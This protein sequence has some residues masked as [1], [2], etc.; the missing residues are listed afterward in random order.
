MEASMDY[1]GFWRR[2]VAWIIDG[3]IGGVLAWILIFQLAY[4]TSSTPIDM[5]NSVPLNYIKSRRLHPH[6][7][8]RNLRASPFLVSRHRFLEMVRLHRKSM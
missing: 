3:V 7:P 5:L 4:V 2:F 1:V 8:R 6:F